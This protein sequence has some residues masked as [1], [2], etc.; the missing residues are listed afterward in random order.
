V[1]AKHTT[2]ILIGKRTGFAFYQDK[3]LNRK[4]LIGVF[5]D[6]AS[7]NNHFDGP[8][9]QLPD[10]FLRGDTL[11]QSIIRADPKV[12]GA[13]D[14]FGNFLDGSGRY[15]IAPYFYYRSEEDLRMID[16]CAKTAQR[17]MSGRYYS[18]FS[19]AQNRRRF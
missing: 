2:H 6:N 13:I 17:K 5:A 1:P 10:N 7:E 8:F 3:F 19:S 16:K 12:A 15:L 11:R 4:I 9:D 18:C 14:R